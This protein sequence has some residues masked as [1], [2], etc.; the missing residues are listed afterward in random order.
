MADPILFA[1]RSSFDEFLSDYD[2]Q[3][4]P[5]FQS[6]S[7]RK[8]VLFG[9]LANRDPQARVAMANRL[10]DDGADASVVTTSGVNLLHVLFSKRTHDVPAEAALLQRLLDGG[11]D[12]NRVERR[13]GAPLAMLYSMGGKD[14]DLVPFYDVIFARDDLDLDKPASR[15]STVRELILHKGRYVRPRM[16]ERVR[17][18]DAAHGAAGR[19]EGEDD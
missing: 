13:D 5:F 10:L 8:T 18:Y 3:V 15:A 4:T 2:P 19:Q 11:A 1:K 17:A 6:P 16:Q 12:I 9:A 14:E 7:T